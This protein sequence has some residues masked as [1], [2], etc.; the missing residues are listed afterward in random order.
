MLAAYALLFLQSDV[1]G[2]MF[3]HFILNQLFCSFVDSTVCLFVLAQRK[4]GL[5]VVLW[6]NTSPGVV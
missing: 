4:Q 1:F 5:R 2:M 3:L 6:K